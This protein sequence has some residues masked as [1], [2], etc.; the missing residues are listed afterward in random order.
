[1]ITVLSPSPALD[2]TYLLDE[3]VV[4]GIHRPRRVLRQA[5]GKGLNL[6]RAAAVLGSRVR[7]IAP[8]GGRI[9]E[10]VAELAAG[11]GLDLEIVRVEEETRMCVSALTDDAAATEFYEPA[12]AAGLRD[13]GSLGWTVLAGS[14]P[15]DGEL[16]RLSGQVA[17]DSS[18]P[19]LGEL[20]EA[21]RPAVLKINVDEA[22]ELLGGS[23]SPSGLAR[24]LHERTGAAVVLTAGSEGAVA[25]DAVGAWRAAPDPQPGRFAIGSGDSFLAGLLVALDAGA[26]LPA[27]LHDA[28]AAGSANT[29]APGG[30]VF[31]RSDFEAARSRIEVV[32]L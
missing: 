13:P 4:G 8:L 31:T 12:P 25:V 5:G 10:L 6:A 11:E 23:G 9:G 1:M 7:V 20:L 16:P 28:S 32:A 24:T 18:G 3:I 22:S 21:T 14:L 26:A 17:I 19:R 15:A 27:A 30:G 2:V 29:R